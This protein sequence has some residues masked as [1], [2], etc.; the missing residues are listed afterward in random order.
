MSRIP[1]GLFAHSPHSRQAPLPPLLG[2]QARI[3]KEGTHAME[4]F[5]GIDVS[6]GSLDVAWRP[7]TRPGRRF[8]NTPAGIAALTELL[9]RQKPALVVLEATGGYQRAAAAQL[10]AAGLPLAVVNPRQVR[11]FARATGKLAK[12]DALDALAIARFAEAV[13]PEPRPLP[14]AQAQA[15]AE[16]V[17]RRRQL[18]QM[19]TAEGNRLAQAR[20]PKVR[21]SLEAVLAE[22]EAQLADVDAELGALIEASPAWRAKADLLK[23]VPGIGDTTARALIAQLPELGAASRQAIAALAG[24]APL[25]RDSGRWRGPRRIGGGRA[26]VRTALYMAAL[27]ASRHNPVIAACY[28]RLRGA[29]KRAKVALVACMR[30]LLVIL[31][32]MLREKKPWRQSAA[33]A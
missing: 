17:D 9:A 15:L 31:N 5:V 25:N 19:R 3:G 32:A 16:L 21:S 24:V 12:T 20:A 1:A 18:V 13:R 2:G 8:E 23:S 26:A 27:T 14:D 30:K 28:R 7:A 6:K 29:G 10:L 11:D 4:L 22:L 33:A